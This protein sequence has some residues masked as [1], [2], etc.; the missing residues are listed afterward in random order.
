MPEE[1]GAAKK[2]ES[3]SAIKELQ[4]NTP[5]RTRYEYVMNPLNVRST[6]RFLIIKKERKKTLQ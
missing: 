5:R 4:E 6:C 2:T 1:N 3:N